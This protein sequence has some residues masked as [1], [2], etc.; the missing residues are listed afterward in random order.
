MGMDMPIV[1]EQ[2]EIYDTGERKVVKEINMELKDIF[3][4]LALR[5]YMWIG[6]CVLIMN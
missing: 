6:I 3:C 2:H 4:L 5:S 1:Q